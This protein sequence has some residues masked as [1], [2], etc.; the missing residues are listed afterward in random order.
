MG[1]T[2][3]RKTRA[4]CVMLG[5]IF[6]AA[7]AGVWAWEQDVPA[8]I[9][10]PKGQKLKAEAHAKGFQVYTCKN[11]GG[12]Y[13]WT[14]KGPDAE[15][16]DKKGK[17][18]GRHFTGPTW[19]WKGK[20]QVTGKMEKSVASPDAGSVAWL[21]LAAT[22]HS[23]KGVLSKVTYIQR[24]NTKGGKPPAGGCDATHEGQET[25]MAYT[26]DYRFYAPK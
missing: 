18:V 22:G 24:L 2:I 16:F 17:A 25:R 14:L 15:L 3:H 20:S 10:V 8:E 19:E 7:Q 1:A 13:A 5:L 12:K 26:A 9:R 4:F 11:D 6:G 21:L 23:G